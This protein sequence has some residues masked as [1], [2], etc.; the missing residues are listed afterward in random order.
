MLFFP[1][2]SS[3]QQS[4]ASIKLLCFA[5]YQLISSA[6]LLRPEFIIYE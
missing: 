4:R 1:F 3:T 5:E 2:E 6:A